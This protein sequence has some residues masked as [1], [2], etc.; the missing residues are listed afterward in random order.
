MAQ[1]FLLLS[2]QCAALA[3]PVMREILSQ[4]V[5][6]V[7]LDAALEGSFQLASVLTALQLWR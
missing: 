2:F 7:R 1:A 6:A 3:R 4:H 5:T